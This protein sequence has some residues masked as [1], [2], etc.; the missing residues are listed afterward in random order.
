MAQAERALGGTGA[1]PPSNLTAGKAGNF[2]AREPH[3]APLT[4]LIIIISFIAA[5]VSGRRGPM[6]YVIVPLTLVLGAEFRR[7]IG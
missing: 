1:G 2:L 7:K 4:F 6:R 3:D 5:M